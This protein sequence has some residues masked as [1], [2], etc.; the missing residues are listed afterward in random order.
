MISFTG[1]TEHLHNQLISGIYANVGREIQSQTVAPW[2]SANDKP[3]AAGNK[4]ITGDAAEQRIKSETMALH[5][6]DRRR[7]KDLALNDVDAYDAYASMLGDHRR[8]KI[9]KIAHDI[10]PASAGGLNN[11]HKT[12]KLNVHSTCKRLTLRRL[13][14]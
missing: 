3:A 1:E 4:P 6:R 8:A 13:G 2:V 14:A 10:V 9:A 7:I 12:S 11:L 5:S